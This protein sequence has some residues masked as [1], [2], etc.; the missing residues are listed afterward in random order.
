MGHEKFYISPSSSSFRPH[1][2][3]MFDTKT[4]QYH[5]RLKM[6]GWRQPVIS[7]E[8]SGWMHTVDLAKVR[9]TSVMSES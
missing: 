1:S 9:C 3:I 4:S 8:I 5:P 6:D 7:V 2:V